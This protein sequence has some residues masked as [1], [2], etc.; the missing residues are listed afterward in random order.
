MECYYP[1]LTGGLIRNFTFFI[2]QAYFF[3]SGSKE[4][5]SG[6]SVN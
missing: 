2:L 5:I 4:K 3:S 6:K 1:S